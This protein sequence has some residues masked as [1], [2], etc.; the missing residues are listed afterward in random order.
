MRTKKTLLAGA[1]SALVVTLTA[2]GCGL[3]SGTPEKAAPVKRV[4]ELKAGQKVSIVLESYN[5]GQAGAWT[6]TFNELIAKFEQ[7]HPNIEVTGQKPQGNSANPASDTVTSLQSQLATGH[8]PDV[9]QLGFSD[10]DF[11]VNQLKAA[12]L[13]DLFGK[14]AVRKNFD[15]ATYP[16]AKNARTLG[17]WKGKTYGVPFVFST[18][19]LYYN[20]ALFTAAGLD[21][22]KPPATWAEVERAALAIKKKTGKDG[23]Y[24]DCLTKSAK[25]WCFQ[26]LVRSNGGRVISEDRTSLRFA[27]PAAVE[28]VRTMRGMVRSGAMP[29]RTQM[30]AVEGFTRGDLGMILES[31]AV[32]GTFEKGAKDKWELRSA[33]MPAFAGKPVVPT[34]SG[35]SLFVLAKDPARQRA[36][37]ELIKFLTSEEA[38]TTISTKIGY[39]PLRTELVNDPAALKPWADKN[40]LIKPNLEQF[41]RMEPWVSFPGASYVQ[42]RDGMMEAVENSVFQGADA[43]TTLRAKQE[44]AAKLIPGGGR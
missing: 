35:A 20:A 30:Q 2:T 41:A 31:S 10:L 42:V 36:A 27:E 33:A 18:P 4:P 22:A 43:A 21:P 26:S 9:A 17:D 39:L 1:V 40:P 5:F 12:P 7:A 32:Q 13:D 16:Y 6:D 24:V 11:T 14:D 25:D 15:G 8:P 3:G 28:T 19:V 23:A 37:W 29:N 38:Y 34:N 44:E